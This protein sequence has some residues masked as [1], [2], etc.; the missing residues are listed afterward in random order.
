M[1]KKTVYS[2]SILIAAL[3]LLGGGLVTYFSMQEKEE[4]PIKWVIVL[5]ARHGEIDKNAKGQLVLNLD[6]GKIQTVTAIYDQANQKEKTLSPTQ[7]DGLWEGGVHTFIK[8][9]L[10]GHLKYGDQ[11]M[12][13]SLESVQ[14]HGYNTAFIIGD[15]HGIEVESLGK[16][17][18]LTL[19]YNYN[20]HVDE[21]MS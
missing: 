9:P 1:N 6:D 14:V 20:P 3:F 17:V 2:V 21:K 5:K 10:N 13:L 16:D 12:H 7:Y 19:E 11:T 4:S 8:G 15:V 18:Q